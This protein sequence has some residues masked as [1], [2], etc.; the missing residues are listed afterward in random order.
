MCFNLGLNSIHKETNDVMSLIEE[1]EKKAIP[2]TIE[3]LNEVFVFVLI[4]SFRRNES[5]LSL[6]Q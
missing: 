2:T 3:K 4:I 6:K 1:K 5:L